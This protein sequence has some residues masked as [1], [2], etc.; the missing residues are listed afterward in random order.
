[1]S[2]VLELRQAT[3]DQVHI[4]L[5]ILDEVAQWMMAKGVQQ[6]DSPAPQAF[7]NFVAEEI[8]RGD[9]YL[10]WLDGVPVGTVR[11]DWE[12]ERDVAD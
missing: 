8:P 11:V 9:F 5:K 2:D 7:V 4:V 3:P 10:A 12:K 1:M 6:W